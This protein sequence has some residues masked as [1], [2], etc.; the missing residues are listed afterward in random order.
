MVIYTK[1]DNKK[2]MPQKANQ[3]TYKEKLYTSPKHQF[4]RNLDPNK[5]RYMS[6]KVH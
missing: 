4:K 5:D 1:K 6:F 3:L 2:P